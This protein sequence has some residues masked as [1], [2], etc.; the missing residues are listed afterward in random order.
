MKKKRVALLMCFVLVLGCL[1]GCSEPKPS[2]QGTGRSV[3][4]NGYRSEMTTKNVRFYDELHNTLFVLPDGEYA[5][6]SGL[7]TLTPTVLDAYGT[8]RIFRVNTP[9]SNLPEWFQLLLRGADTDR[10]L[11][12]I[13]DKR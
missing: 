12:D 1:T 9:L 4:V 13:Y 11:Y 2:Y 7:D 6:P 10:R 5:L 8:P 3:S